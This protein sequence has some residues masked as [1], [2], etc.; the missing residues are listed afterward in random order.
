MF[1]IALDLSSVSTI[2]I[3]WALLLKCETIVNILW[4]LVSNTLCPAN[5]HGRDL[6]SIFQQN[7]DILWIVFEYTLRKQRLEEDKVLRV[8]WLWSLSRV[9]HKLPHSP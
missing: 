4:K 2:Y 3:L 9:R 7:I 5:T 8:I 1:P 6:N